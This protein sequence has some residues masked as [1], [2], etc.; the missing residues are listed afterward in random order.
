M[1]ADVKKKKRKRKRKEK[2]E[3]QRETGWEAISKVK[4]YYV[5]GR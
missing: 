5:H 4:L 3:S 1:V 2:K